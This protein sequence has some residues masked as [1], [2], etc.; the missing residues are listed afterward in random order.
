[1]RTS[2]R[3][4]LTLLAGIMEDLAREASLLRRLVIPGEVLGFCLLDVF[5]V[6]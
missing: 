5:S 1:M 2:D 4:A 6:M 3:T